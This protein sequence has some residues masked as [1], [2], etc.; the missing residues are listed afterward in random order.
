[1]SHEVSTDKS[2]DASST[3]LSDSAS[4]CRLPAVKSVPTTG[5]RDPG[6]GPG[7]LSDTSGQDVEA[8]SCDREEM[9]RT[10]TGSALRHRA[11]E[12]QTKAR[13]F[14]GRSNRNQTGNSTSF[15][16]LFAAFASLGSFKK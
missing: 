3:C 7:Q 4:P 14:L 13:A 9:G 16:G 1:M 5:N 6:A 12:H 2:T 10:E 15:L 8:D 11:T